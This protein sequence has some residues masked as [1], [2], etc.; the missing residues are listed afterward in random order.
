[1]NK[2]VRFS[3]G[4]VTFLI[5]ITDRERQEQAKEDGFKLVVDKEGTPI[6]VDANELI[7]QKKDSITDLI[8]MV[9]QENNDTLRM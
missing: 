7:Q 1:M 2:Y 4:A 8:N 3:N 9:Q 6:V 5:N